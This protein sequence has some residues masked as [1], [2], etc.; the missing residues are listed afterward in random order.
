MG[1]D[2]VSLQCVRHPPVSLPR[3]S[4]G[5][6]EVAALGVARAEV[7]GPAKRITRS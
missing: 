1:P 2:A 6:S 7:P 3:L 5:G 4:P